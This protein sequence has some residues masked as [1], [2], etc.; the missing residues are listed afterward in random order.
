MFKSSFSASIP[1]ESLILCIQTAHFTHPIRFLSCLDFMINS[2]NMA[3]VS[4]LDAFAQT[5]F[6]QP[7]SLFPSSF[8]V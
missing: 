6:L 7:N 8:L 1:L 4:L 5:L 2:L 3:L